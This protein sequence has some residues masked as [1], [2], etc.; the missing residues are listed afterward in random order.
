MIELRPYQTQGIDF[1]K[2][3]RYSYFGVG[4]GGGK[5]VMSLEATKPFDKILII[6]P[7]SLLLNWRDEI[8]KWYGS[9][10]IT[11]INKPLQALTCGKYTIISYERAMQKDYFLKILQNEF[12][13]VIVDEAHRIKNKD[14]AR[15]EA[16]L[17]WRSGKSRLLTHPSV[18]KAILLSGTPM[19]QR[20]VELYAPVR[21][22]RPDLLTPYDTY[23]S[24]CI[25]YC[26][27]YIDDWGKMIAT[28]AT[29]QKE[30]AERVRD[31][32]Y[33]V[34]KSE[35][36][37]D[38]PPCQH[39]LIRF[40]VAKNIVKEQEKLITWNLE[41]TDLVYNFEL[42]AALQHELAFEKIALSVD[43]IKNLVSNGEKTV[44]F[45]YHLDIIAA[46]KLG[47]EKLKPKVITGAI[48]HSRRHTI[49]TDF[50]QDQDS[51]LLICQIK[52]AGEGLNINS[53]SQVVFVEFSWNPA[54]IEQCFKRVHR[55]GV[56]TAVQVHYLV[57]SNSFD[58][59][60]LT[61]ILKKQDVVNKFNSYLLEN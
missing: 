49:V 34:P 26:G 25:R 6:A 36:E 57:A 33:Y 38:L 43:Y 48:S 1:A 10:Y 35:I 53:A 61:N 19:M 58:D 15:T 5:T 45:C 16:L 13:A 40:D 7:A 4:C 60:K 37:K 50:N 12:Q 55:Q 52:S 24:Y 54:D 20:P 18:E 31:F 3:R 2:Q 51:K 42:G 47:L 14:A 56:K 22:L 27:G 32:L 30:L 46:L 29:Y 9:A 44:V 23:K 59:Y 39:H 17:G 21:G 8:T 28:G 41:K 11:V